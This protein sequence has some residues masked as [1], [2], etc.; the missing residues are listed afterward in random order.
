MRSNDQFNTTIY[1]L[2]DRLRGIEGTRDVLLINPEDIARAGLA[3]GQM[4]SLVSDADDKVHREVGPLKVTPFKLPDG[5]VGSY[6]LEMNLSSPCRTMTRS[7]RR[8]PINRFRCA[9]GP[10]AREM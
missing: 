3:D 1:G 4:V 2:S 9:S 7:Q 8:L 10:D 6:Y 5:C